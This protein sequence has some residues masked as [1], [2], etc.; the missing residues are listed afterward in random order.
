MVLDTLKQLKVISRSPRSSRDEHIEI[1]IVS[2]HT[3]IYTKCFIR[4]AFCKDSFIELIQIQHR[5]H[6]TKQE[7]L[8]TAVTSKKEQTVFNLAQ[9]Q[10]KSNL[11]CYHRYRLE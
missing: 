2:F 9:F 10:F 4:T 6:Y 3:I 1:C 8:M 5:L 7:I 11:Q